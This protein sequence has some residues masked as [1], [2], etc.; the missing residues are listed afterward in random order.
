MKKKTIRNIEEVSKEY[1]IE[2]MKGAKLMHQLC[3]DFTQQK[4]NKNDLD[5]IIECESHCDRIKE[6]YIEILFKSKRALPFLV[7]DRYKI[8]TYVDQ[9]LG[10]IEYLSRFLKIY[11]FDLDKDYI[12]QF[13]EL[14]DIIL[15]I[16]EEMIE[17]LHL[18]ENN[19]DEAFKKTYTIQS[20]RGDARKIRFSILERIYKNTD[21]NKLF[22]A[23]E[24]VNNLYHIAGFVEDIADYLRGLIIKY[25]SR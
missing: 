14:S 9:V 22:L 21:S 23:S 6:E 1:Y 3:I 5:M 8:I 17:T 24:L 19:F 16:I 20:Q 10:R 25:P 13:K 18:I 4:L 7:E 12:K 15:T 11:P 2:F